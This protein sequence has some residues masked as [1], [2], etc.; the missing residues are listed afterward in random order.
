MDTREAELYFY[1]LVT[2]VVLI[3]I[4]GLYVISLLRY[5]RKLTALYNEKI[6]IEIKTLERER[7]RLSE[8]IHDELGPQ[9]L[10]IKMR[11]ELLDLSNQDSYEIREKTLDIIDQ[12]F[13]NV[14]RVSRNLNPKSIQESG[15]VSTLKAHIEELGILH[16][17]I[18]KFKTN[19]SNIDCLSNDAQLH[20]FRAM[21]EALNNSIKHSSAKNIC[22]GIK[23]NK[24]QYVFEISDNGKGFV[25]PVTGLGLGLS[26]IKSR[27]EFLGGEFQVLSRQQ[28]GTSVFLLIPKEKK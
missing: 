6:N 9:L 22:I 12:L 20:V 18:F 1:V 2:A 17:I 26:N 27:V 16:K 28:I 25:Y 23:E 10:S 13:Q 19:C 24:E 5:H 4:F 8:D 14:R 21:Q 15:I 11:I 7:K 3:F